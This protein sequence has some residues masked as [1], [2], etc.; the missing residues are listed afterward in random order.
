MTTWAGWYP[1]PEDESRLRYWDGRMWTEATAPIWSIV[2]AMVFLKERPARKLLYSA[3][4]VLF[5]VLLATL[6]SLM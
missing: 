1:D 3:G 6:D 4:V 5:G 2:G